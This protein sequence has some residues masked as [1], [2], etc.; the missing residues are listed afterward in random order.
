MMRM[1][2]NKLNIELKL[3]PRVV[4]VFE[5][6]DNDSIKLVSMTSF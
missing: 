2:E 3:T 4:G 5:H 6:F 1:A